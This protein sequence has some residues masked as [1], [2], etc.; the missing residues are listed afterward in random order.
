MPFSTS[1]QFGSFTRVKTRR[2]FDFESPEVEVSDL[3]A[4]TQEAKEK[5]EK[6]EAKEKKVVEKAH[7]RP[8]N[9]DLEVYLHIMQIGC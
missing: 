4:E 1:H 2:F 5:K 8:D 9:W 3:N 7:E 6:K